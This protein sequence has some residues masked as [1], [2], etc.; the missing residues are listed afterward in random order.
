MWTFFPF[1]V[2]DAEMSWQILIKAWLD[3]V[4][5]KTS[6][7]K[8]CFIGM[9]LVYFVVIAEDFFSSLKLGTFIFFHLRFCNSSIILS[10][11]IL[12]AFTGN[13]LFHLKRC[14]LVA[15]FTF[16]LLF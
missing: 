2:E 4:Y 3:Y 7:P 11:I 1:I 16:F 5:H 6:D 15:E 14:C 10:S 8:V 13:Y 9:A 12:S